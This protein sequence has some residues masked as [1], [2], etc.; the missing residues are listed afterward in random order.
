VLVTVP[1]RTARWLMTKIEDIHLARGW[2]YFI[3]YG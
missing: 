1:T 3:G 2:G